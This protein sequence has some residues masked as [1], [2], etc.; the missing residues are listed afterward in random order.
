MR[1]SYV[2]RTRI[3]ATA[4][5]VF[6]WHEHPDAF[7]QLTPPWERVRVLRRQGGIRDGASLSLLVGPMP[8][9]LRWDLRH[10][11]YRYGSEFTDEQV[12]GPFKVWRHTHRMIPEGD[13][14][15]VL[16]DAIDYEL[17]FGRI[18]HCLGGAYIRSKLNRLFTFRHD[19]TRQQFAP[20]SKA[21]T[22]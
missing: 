12:A 10:H 8:F 6:D 19:V 17:P 22:T 2:K 7:K 5:A 16:E 1:R 3:P 21:S 14:A 18:G 20:T 15:C 9:A 4:Q 11:S 13:E